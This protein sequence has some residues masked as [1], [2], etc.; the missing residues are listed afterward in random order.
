MVAHTLR[1]LGPKAEATRMVRDYVA[2]LYLPAAR[3]SRALAQSDFSGARELAAWQDRVGKAWH[4][5]RIEHVEAEEGEQRPGARLAVR[6]MV[7]L[8]ELAPDDVTVQVA[9]GRAGDEDEITDPSYTDLALEGVPDGQPVA[10]YAGEIELGGP[11]PFGYTVRVLPR[12]RL[13]ASTAELGLVT[14]PAAPAGMTNGDL[15]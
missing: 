3:S 9:Y 4:T 5:I 14:V 11:G 8:G 12:H 1:T 10:R 13:L 2:Q 7:A 15:R 6:A